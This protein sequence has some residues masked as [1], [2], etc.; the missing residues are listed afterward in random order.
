MG[1]LGAAQKQSRVRP[2]AAPRE[3][4]W[5]SGWGRPRSHLLANSMPVAM[6]FCSRSFI[7]A[8]PSCSASDSGPMGRNSSTPLGPRRTCAAAQGRKPE[9]V[10]QGGCGQG[11]ARGRSSCTPRGPT[12]AEAERGVD[13]GR[14]SG[15]CEGQQ[16]GGWQRRGTRARLPGQ[17]T[18]T[19][20]PATTLGACTNL[21]GKAPAVGHHHKVHSATTNQ[22]DTLFPQTDLGGK[23]LEVG[24]HLGL[25]KRALHHVG[26]ARQAQQHALRH[27]RRGVGHGQRG[28]A[29]GEGRE[30]RGDARGVCTKPWTARLRERAH[31]RACQRLRTKPHK[32]ATGQPRTRARLGL[33]HLGARVLDALGELGHLGEGVGGWGSRAGWWRWWAEGRRSRGGCRGAGRQRAGLRA[34][35]P[36][37]APRQA[38]ACRRSA[39][40][41]RAALP[42]RRSSSHYSGAPPRR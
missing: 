40:R 7:L 5:H 25:H 29:C 3:K 37:D 16:A 6:F 23:V 10:A 33:H 4:G 35:A 11:V 2:S 39:P 31:A 26:L 12:W 15:G 14:H 27:A 18:K 1:W 17:R 28:G 24:H 42:R 22:V 32:P 8:S 36:R 13:A 38:P 34:Q 20:R 9:R 30:G 21:G 19:H 41:P